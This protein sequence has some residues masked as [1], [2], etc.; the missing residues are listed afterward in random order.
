M[1]FE[2][3]VARRYFAMSGALALIARTFILILA[4]LSAGVA[5]HYLFPSGTYLAAI[6]ATLCLLVVF[7]RYVLTFRSHVAFIST[8]SVLGLAVGVTALVISLALLSGLQDRIRAQMAQRSPHLVV[9][10]ARGDRLPDPGRVV[11]VLSSLPGVVEVAPVIEGRGWLCDAEGRAAVPV[12]YRNATR[13]RSRAPGGP[14]GPPPARITVHVAARTV[15]ETGSLVRLVSS[16]TRLS[17]IGPIPVSVVL[18][19]VE[20]FQPGALEKTPQV[21]IPEET[22]RLLSGMVSG[23]RA[24]E[25]HLKDPESAGAAAA[26]L[27]RQLP[28]SD[29]VETWRELNAPLSFALHLEKAV[30]FATVALIILVAAFNIVSNIALL[31]VEK[32]RDLG[33]LASLGATPGSLAR[34]YLALGAIIGALG[35]SCG[36]AVGVPA[37]ELLDRFRLLPLPADVYLMSHVP[38]AVHPLEVVLVVVFAQAT[39]LAAAVLPARAGARLAPGEALR[40]S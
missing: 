5:V 35:T 19:V 8:I 39:A 38:F 30:I 27:V 3:F 32:K 24:F 33:V 34:I 37:A 40:L 11:R 2:S 10:P 15:S 17:P 31:V 4:L 6:L 9:S 23:A 28:E 16:R 20:T 18:R 22:A 26:L 14:A 1:S 25:A 29:R 7:V 12:R 13:S 36:I 21:E